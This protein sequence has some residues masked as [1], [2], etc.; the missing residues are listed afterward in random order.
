MVVRTTPLNSIPLPSPHDGGPAP[1]DGMILANITAVL[2]FLSFLGL[3]TLI[4]L[5]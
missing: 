1:A 2:G 5:G 4:L 3:M